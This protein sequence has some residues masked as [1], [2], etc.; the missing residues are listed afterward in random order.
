MLILLDNLCTCT[1]LSFAHYSIFLLLSWIALCNCWTPWY[2]TRMDILIFAHM[3]SLYTL[4]MCNSC[5]WSYKYMLWYFWRKLIKLIRNRNFIIKLR[6][7]T[8]VE[9]V[10][11]LSTFSINFENFS[12]YLTSSYLQIMFRDC[13]QIS[14]V[15]ACRKSVTSTN[16]TFNQTLT[17]RSGTVNISS[18]YP[19]TQP[20]FTAK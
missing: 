18:V 6:Y 14:C 1:T 3:T 10:K 19:E 13:F 4:F 7:V 15:K 16:T 20:Y 11:S 2:F 5:I 12:M 17:P 9:I 8:D